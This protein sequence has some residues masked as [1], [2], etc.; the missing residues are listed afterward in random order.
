MSQRAQIGD[1]W[2]EIMRQD[3]Q[4]LED[5]QAAS[6]SPVADRVAGMSPV[7]EVAT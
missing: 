4:V 5:L 6:R 1:A 7:W 2:V 3:T